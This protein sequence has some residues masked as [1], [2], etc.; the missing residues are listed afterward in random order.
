MFYHHHRDF[1]GMITN[2]VVFV[3]SCSCRQ[4]Y[5]FLLFVVLSTSVLSQRLGKSLAHGQHE[6]HCRRPRA[7]GLESLGFVRLL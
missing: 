7:R 1:I 2:M 4:Y 5:L 3:I 6:G